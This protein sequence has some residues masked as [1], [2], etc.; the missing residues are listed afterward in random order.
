MRLRGI[1]NPKLYFIATFIL[2]A[3]SVWMIFEMRDVERVLGST[4]LDIH[5]LPVGFL[6]GL[7]VGVPVGIWRLRAIRKALP[8]L[9][10][11]FFLSEASVLSRSREGENARSMQ[12]RGYVMA[13]AI[14]F[15]LALYTGGRTMLLGTMVYYILGQYLTGQL[16]PFTRLYL[17]L[18]KCD[19]TRLP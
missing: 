13:F 9:D 10:G 14:W 12:R 15:M 17:E 16:L 5:L 6:L 1:F 8:E 3:I 19:S 7:G 18:K 2:V 4:R 11:Q